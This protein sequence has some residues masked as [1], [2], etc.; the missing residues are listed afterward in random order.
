MTIYVLYFWIL[1]GATH[2]LWKKYPNAKSV[3]RCFVIRVIINIIS[4]TL[5]IF[6]IGGS[7]YYKMDNEERLENYTAFVLA[8]SYSEWLIV[9]TIQTNIF[10]CIFDANIPKTTAPQVT[11]LKRQ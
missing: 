5:L 6:Q 8:T 11:N 4:T 3:K 10:L 1:L 2:Y 9:L 7:N